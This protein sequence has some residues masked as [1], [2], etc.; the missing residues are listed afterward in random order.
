MTWGRNVFLKYFWVRNVF[1]KY[2]LGAK[3]PSKIWFGCETSS[4]TMKT[5]AKR[6]SYL[7]GG[8]ETSFLSMSWGRNVAGSRCN[9]CVKRQT[10]ELPYVKK[11]TNIFRSPLEQ[12][13]NYV[14]YLQ[15]CRC[16]N[17]FITFQ[18]VLMEFLCYF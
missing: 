3:R 14:R 6:L 5:G 9:W 4:R 18:A 8:G 16:Q 11:C 15:I 2:G 17:L 10:Y 13:K 7:W 12:H 1:L